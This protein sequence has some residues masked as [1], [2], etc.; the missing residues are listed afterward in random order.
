MYDRTWYTPVS[1][2]RKLTEPQHR[3]QRNK[4]GCL[5]TNSQKQHL[6]DGKEW[7]RGDRTYGL[8]GV[9][10]SVEA[11]LSIWVTGLWLLLCKGSGGLEGRHPTEEELRLRCPA[12]HLTCLSP[13]CYFFISIA[14]FVSFL[15]DELC[16]LTNLTCARMYQGQHDCFLCSHPR[17]DMLSSGGQEIPN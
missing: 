7:E 13:P 3:N 9:T 6:K 16:I 11:G 17:D 14:I 15:G 5:F 8:G 10:E 4:H 1:T 12:L 2:G